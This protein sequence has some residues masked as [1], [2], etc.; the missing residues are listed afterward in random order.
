MAGLLRRAVGS[1]PALRRSVF[2]HQPTSACDDG[3][4]SVSVRVSR[5]TILANDLKGG[6]TERRRPIKTCVTRSS[7]TGTSRDSQ[8]S[9]AWPDASPAVARGALA[10]VAIPA[11]S[12]WREWSSR[13]IDLKWIWPTSSVRWRSSWPTPSRRAGGSAGDGRY[14]N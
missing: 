6:R 3:V 4:A 14:H 10:C 12:G 8:S 2:F 9:R 1:A 7:F 13:Q 5:S 11:P